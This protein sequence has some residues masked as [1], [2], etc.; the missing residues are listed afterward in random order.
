M[1]SSCNHPNQHSHPLDVLHHPGIYGLLEA[2]VGVSVKHVVCEAAG[3]F[4][5]MICQLRHGLLHRLVRG[6]QEDNLAVGRLGHC[7][8]GLEVSDLHGGCGAQDVGGLSHQLGRFDLGTC[9][10]DL[11][12]AN[13]FR[14]GRHGERILQVVAEDDV[15]DEHALDPDTPAGRDVFNNLAD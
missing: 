11:G 12:F 3:P 13:T 14:L 1:S 4:A 9:C 8:H 6:R 2:V 15:L 5:G 10:N 7:L